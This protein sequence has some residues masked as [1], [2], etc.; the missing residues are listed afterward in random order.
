MREKI[1]SLLSRLI[2]QTRDFSLNV[3]LATGKRKL[4]RDMD[5][6]R[7]K[8][9]RSRAGNDENVPYKESGIYESNRARFL[10]SFTPYSIA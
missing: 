1:S 3:A 2:A 8:L 5:G 10:R 6:S 7:K 9:E 4:P